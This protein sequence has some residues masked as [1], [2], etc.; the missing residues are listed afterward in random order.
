M[1]ISMLSA[2]ISSPSSHYAKASLA[3]TKERLLQVGTA[4]LV[5]CIEKT[6]RHTAHAP[7]QALKTKPPRPL[8]SPDA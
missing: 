5:T 1:V 7:S 2:M 3:R 6:D 4:G 8:L